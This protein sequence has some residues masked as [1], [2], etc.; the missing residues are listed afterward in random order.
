MLPQYS[1]LR[2]CY[3]RWSGFRSLS[4]LC[5]SLP[6]QGLTG[7]CF[8]DAQSSQPYRSQPWHTPTEKIQR[9]L[10]TSEEGNSAVKMAL[11]R[12]LLYWQNQR[13]ERGKIDQFYVR[14]VSQCHSLLY[15]PPRRG[16]VHALWANV[17]K[18]RREAKATWSGVWLVRTWVDTARALDS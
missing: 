2:D 15:L 16:L 18:P 4:K 12:H 13:R 10:C 3:R 9:C 8:P 1:Y 5:Y 11:T 17:Q 14:V 6:S 7:D